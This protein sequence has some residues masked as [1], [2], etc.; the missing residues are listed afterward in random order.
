MSW[1][2]G[3]VYVLSDT[4]EMATPP[5]VC[6]LSEGETLSSLPPSPGGLVGGGLPTAILS[7]SPETRGVGKPTE[8]PQSLLPTPPQPVMLSGGE[9]GQ[10]EEGLVHLG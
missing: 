5:E 1:A 10:L 7:P 3:P 2:E 9:G 8:S 6:Q 4:G